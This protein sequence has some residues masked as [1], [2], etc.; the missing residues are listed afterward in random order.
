MSSH[1]I[2]RAARSRTEEQRQQDLVRIQKYCGLEDDIRQQISD[3]NYGAETFQLTSKLLRLNPEYY[4]IWN[5]RRRCLIYGL[6]SKPSA[7]S[8]HSKES[9]NTSAIGTHTAS[10][11]ASLPSS[12][13]EIPPRPAPPTAGKTGTTTDS[14]ADTNV[15]RSE[16]GFTVPLLMEFPKCYWIWN[17]RLWTLDRA[18][19]R[20]DVSIAR[21]IWEEE[22][23]LVSKMLTKDRRNFHAWGYRRH[24]VAQLE[25]SVL[26]GQSLVELEFE[27]TTKKIHEDL[28]NFSAWHN[29]SQL[30]TRLL[31]ERKADNASR[32]DLL[33][34]EI[35]L[36]REALNVGPEDQSLWYYHQFLVLNLANPSSTRQIAPNLTMEERKSYIYDEVTEIKDLLQDYKDIKWIY[37]ALVEYAIAFNQLTGQPF[38]PES[39]SDVTSWLQILRK[40]DPKRNGRWS[41]LEKDL[42]SPQT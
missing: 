23:G 31:N 16:L 6:L 1:G 34:K 15:I 5:A 26:N 24:V 25:S 28:S 18:I 17:Y 14:D 19:E 35:E 40:L 29:R 10:S 33:D 36:I 9:Q 12:S 42:G 22:L 38:E 2:A 21:H 7:G 32:K 37:E 30:I 41:D 13:T 27:Y 11:D 8:P 3:N 39:R 20:L 4:T